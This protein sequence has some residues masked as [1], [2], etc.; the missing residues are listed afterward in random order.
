MA[1]LPANFTFNQNNLQDFVDCPR[2]FEL[3]HLL[4]QPWPAIQSEPAQ[5][6]E[7]RILRGQ[8][9]HQ[10]VH[11]HQLGLPAD[12]I[13][14][15]AAGDEL[16][17][18]WWGN[19]LASPPTPLPE[20]RYPEFSLRCNAGGHPFLAKFDLL[21][22]EP[23]Q[24]VLIVDWKTGIK[25]APRSRLRQRIQTR[26]YPWMA[27]KAAQHLNGGSPVQPEQVE[28]IY[29]F[30]AEPLY[31]EIFSYSAKQYSQDGQELARL[32]A[33]VEHDLAS[34][35][36]LTSDEHKCMFCN[37][38]S[39]CERGERAGTDISDEELSDTGLTEL[40]L[41]FDQIAEIEF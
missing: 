7:L 39:L 1:E 30:T 26:L 21:C 19:Y 2:R 37:Y 27:V 4:R 20:Q 9:F 41:D 8:R 15:Q 33:E 3:R 23:G 40:D 22:I 36:P 17:Q 14:P 6:N 11:Q 24:K 25:K 16:L 29:W 28:M 5:E 18:D 38:R 34:G 32:A 35:F 10:M 13:G 12:K 31:P